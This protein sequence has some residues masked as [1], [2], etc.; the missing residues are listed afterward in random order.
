MT[1]AIRY[2]PDTDLLRGKATIAARATQNLSRFNLDLVGL[3][4]H[5]IRVDGG[6]REMVTRR[7]GAQDHSAPR[8]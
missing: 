7:S 2:D 6:P 3:D 4:V 8:R 1:W 5:R